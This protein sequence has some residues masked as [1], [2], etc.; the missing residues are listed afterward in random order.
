MFVFCC[1]CSFVGN[2]IPPFYDLFIF[3]QRSHFSGRLFYLMRVEF[4]G[5][6]RILLNIGRISCGFNLPFLLESLHIFFC[7][8]A[9]N[10]RVE[11]SGALADSMRGS[12]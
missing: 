6:F 2:V 10:E 9:G 5:A 1:S 7:R 8:S 3:T 4:D 12:L 11:Y